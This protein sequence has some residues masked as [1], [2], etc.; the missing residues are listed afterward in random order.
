MIFG[1]PGPEAT[2][3]AAAVAAAAAARLA[4]ARAAGAARAVAAVEVVGAAAAADDAAAVWSE[5]GKQ[6]LG[7]DFLFLGFVPPMGVQDPKT[8]VLYHKRQCF[9]GTSP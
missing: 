3:V 2:A 8:E 6:K 7:R 4:A 5:S 9:G 1:L